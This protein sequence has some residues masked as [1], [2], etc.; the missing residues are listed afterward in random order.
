MGNC[1]SRRHRRMIR[2]IQSL[3]RRAPRIKGCD[4]V[5]ESPVYQLLYLHMVKKREADS[6]YATL[7]MSIPVR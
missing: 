6:P 4:V 5:D 3:E 7:Y 2:P 1:P